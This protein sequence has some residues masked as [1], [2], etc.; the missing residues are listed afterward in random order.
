MGS[1]TS[2]SISISSRSMGTFIADAITTNLFF[3]GDQA[4]HC[5]LGQGVQRTACDSWVRRVHQG[6]HRRLWEVST[7]Y[8]F[9]QLSKAASSITSDCIPNMISD[10]QRWIIEP[11]WFDICPMPLSQLSLWS[12]IKQSRRSWIL[13]LPGVEATARELRRTTSPNWLVE[14][15][16]S[17]GLVSAQ[18]MDR[19]RLGFVWGVHPLP[20]YQV[21]HWR[22]PGPLLHPVHQQAVHLRLG[23]QPHGSW[24]EVLRACQSHIHVRPDISIVVFHKRPSRS[25]HIPVH[26]F[27]L[28][29]ISVV[30]KQDRK[31]RPHPIRW[32]KTQEL[33]TAL[34]FPD[35]SKQIDIKNHL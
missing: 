1:T 2:S 21:L 18:P 19:G 8:R 17:G 13:K 7:M 16:T 29:A 35:W 31:F 3:Q 6:H 22:L 26:P 25:N 28:W 5:D 24:G 10:C 34:I 30:T 9:R 14:I 32:A 11:V 12:G 20:T 33:T 4:E 27:M 15:P 23:A